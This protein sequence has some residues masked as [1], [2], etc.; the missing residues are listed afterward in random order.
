MASRNSKDVLL[1]LSSLILI[2]LGWSLYLFIIYRI[3][4]LS[5]FGFS[6]LPIQFGASPEAFSIIFI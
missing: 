1:M 5:K 6:G 2:I 3:D 4:D